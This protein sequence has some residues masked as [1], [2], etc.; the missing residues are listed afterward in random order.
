MAECLTHN[1][2][3][4]NKRIGGPSRRWLREEC[5]AGRLPARKI[6]R[7]WRMTD[8]DIASA[9]KI[10]SNDLRPQRNSEMSFVTGLTQTSRKRIVGP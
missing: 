3:E 4:A 9:L 5:A 7:E 10:M 6:G 8:D 2:V 1:L